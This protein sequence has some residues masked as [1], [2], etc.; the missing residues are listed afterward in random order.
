MTPVDIR[1]A[2]LGEMHRAI[3]AAAQDGLR[4][5][6]NGGSDL[7]YLPGV[8]LSASEKRALGALTHSSDLRSA[9][10][11]VLRDAAARPLFQLFTLVDGVAD[12]QNWSGT[13]LG[14]SIT[15]AEPD[16]DSV[17]MWHDDF[18][19]SYWLYDKDRVPDV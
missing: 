7:S 19:E 2:L 8:E 17:T 11:K 3:D 14:A 6:E 10:K 13:W 4:S 1:A 16:E 12:P 18:F 5:L 15:V 9:L